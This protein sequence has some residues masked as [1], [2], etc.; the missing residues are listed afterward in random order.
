[1][2][3]PLPNRLPT[4]TVGVSIAR[5]ARLKGRILRVMIRPAPVWVGAWDGVEDP[6]SRKRPGEGSSS[7][8]RRTRS[9]SSGMR[10]HS[11]MTRGLGSVVKRDPMAASWARS[12][13][14]ST[15]MKVVP[16]A[17]AVRVFPTARAPSTLTAGTD[18]SSSWR[19]WSMRRGR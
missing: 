6:V 8:A 11:S 13:G 7:T 2:P 9:H 17:L 14:S 5:S 12:S 3:R 10:C 4:E 19:R 1:M 18:R 16:W 15:A